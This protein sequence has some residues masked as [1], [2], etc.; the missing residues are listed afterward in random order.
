MYIA[1]CRDIFCLY[2]IF[3][4]FSLILISSKVNRN[5]LH[6]YDK[7]KDNSS[8]IIDKIIH[9]CWNVTSDAVRQKRGMYNKIWWLTFCSRIHENIFNITVIIFL[10]GENL[11]PKQEE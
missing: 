2:K 11:V 3:L 5:Y 4:S 7:M 10:A 9:I 1:F 6:Y 8:I